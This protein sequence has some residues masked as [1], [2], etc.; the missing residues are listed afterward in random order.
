[1]GHLNIQYTRCGR[2]E[3]M[4]KVLGN[5]IIKT[6][7][8]IPSEFSVCF[9]TIPNFNYSVFWPGNGKFHHKFQKVQMHMGMTRGGGGGY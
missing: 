6:L 7:K 4:K 5:L 2:S 3:T 9:H 8:F 1:M